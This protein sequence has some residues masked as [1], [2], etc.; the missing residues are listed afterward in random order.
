MQHALRYAASLGH[1]ARTAALLSIA[2][3]VAAL[4]PVEAQAA[5]LISEVFYDAVGSDNGL[6]FVELSGTPGSSLDGLELVGVN[7]SNG[8]EGPV[9][10]LAG[11]VSAD[12]LFVVAD[13][14]GDGTSLVPGADFI[15]NFDFQNG[16]DSIV[17]RLADAI[18]DAIGY[19]EFDLAEIFAGEGSAATDPPAGSSLARRFANLDTDDNAVDFEILSTPTPDAALFLPVPEPTSSTLLALGL[20]GLAAAGRKPRPA[21]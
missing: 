4:Y 21:V 10:R 3:L 6:S 16:P 7:G 13:D 14:Q 1:P 8:A 12:G 5:P 20:A 19:G 15:A 18:L 9:I 11:S 17:L 2:S